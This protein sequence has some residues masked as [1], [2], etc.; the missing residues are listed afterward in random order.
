MNKVQIFAYSRQIMVDE[1][2]VNFHTKK[3]ALVAESSALQRSIEDM[4]RTSVSYKNIV[5]QIATTIQKILKLNKKIRK[6][7]LFV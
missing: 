4:D 6:N 3:S 1:D 5:D 7:V 2:Q